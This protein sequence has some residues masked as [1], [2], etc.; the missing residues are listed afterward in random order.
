[1][2]PRVEAIRNHPRVGRGSCT[3]IDEAMTD[4]ELIDALNED[5]VTTP[6]AAIAWAIEQ[7]GLHLE[8]GTNQRWGE[9]DDPQLQ[10]YRDWIDG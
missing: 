8:Q 2:E 6:E 5:N 7:E 1:M 3:S 9:D 4:Q 10:A